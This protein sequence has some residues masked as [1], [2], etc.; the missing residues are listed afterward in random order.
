MIYVITLVGK[1]KNH[2]RKG[3]TYTVGDVLIKSFSAL[4]FL[5]LL[6]TVNAGP[7]VLYRHSSM[8]FNSLLHILGKCI[9][10]NIYFLIP[11]CSYKAL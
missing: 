10:L 11:Q 1:C 3:P 4:K 7:S 2:K 5:G 8:S 6:W 9:V